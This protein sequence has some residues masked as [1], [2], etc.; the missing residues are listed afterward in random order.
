MEFNKVWDN[1]NIICIALL[2]LICR[3]KTSI[4]NSFVQRTNIS[5]TGNDVSMAAVLD[6]SHRS[7]LPT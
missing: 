1:Q 6:V 3:G 4:Q 7:V 5:L 2:V